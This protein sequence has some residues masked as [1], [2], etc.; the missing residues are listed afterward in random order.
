MSTAQAIDDG[1][2]WLRQRQSRISVA[3]PAVAGALVAPQVPISVP[4][5]ASAPAA[6][7]S[8]PTVSSAPKFR[9]V[10]DA[11]YLALEQLGLIGLKTSADDIYVV[12]A[13][14]CRA[15]ALDVTGREIQALYEKRFERR[16]E[17]GTIS[18]RTGEL[19]TAGRISRRSDVRV[20][21]VTQKMA[22]PFYVL[23]KQTRMAW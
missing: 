10:T 19:L 11:S 4:V 20:C 15:G 17:S 18:A 5:V 7:V 3:A 13:A 9:V 8:A 1:L 22:R 6:S 12:I 14:A 21:S 16:I 2:A 23:A